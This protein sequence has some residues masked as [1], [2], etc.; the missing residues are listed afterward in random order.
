[1]NGAFLPNSGKGLNSASENSSGNTMPVESFML[2]MLSQSVG[3]Q[4]NLKK[5]FET[6]GR[7]PHFGGLA[8]AGLEIDTSM[9]TSTDGHFQVTCWVI[10]AL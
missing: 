2:L 8:V 3:D 9:H 1:V 10:D 6:A 5:L 4:T 7:C